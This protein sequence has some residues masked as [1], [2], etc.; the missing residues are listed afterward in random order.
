LVSSYRFVLQP[1]HSD[2]STLYSRT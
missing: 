1:M 2:Q